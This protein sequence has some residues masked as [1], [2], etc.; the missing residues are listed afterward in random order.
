MISR[1][2]VLL[3]A[4]LTL[5]GNAVAANDP[6]A[7]WADAGQMVLVTVPGWNVLEGTLRTYQRDHGGAWR[8][9]GKARP[10]VIGQRGSA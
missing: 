6:A 2:A 7:A 10:V 3:I 4:G 1:L 9:V 5:A 8:E